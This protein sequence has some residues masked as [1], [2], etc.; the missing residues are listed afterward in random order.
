MLYYWIFSL[1]LALVYAFWMTRYRRDWQATPSAQAPRQAPQT[2]VAVLLAARNEAENVADCLRCLVAQDYPKALLEIW[3]VDDYS[4]DATPQILA[5]WA[6]NYSQVH[7]FSLAHLRK[8]AGKKSA[9]EQAILHSRS[10][11]IVT[12]DADCQMG[13]Q[14]LSQLVGVYEEK[15]ARF[16]AAPVCFHQCQ[17]AFERWQALDFAGMMGITAA[18]IRGRYMYMCNGANLAY[19]RHLFEAVGGF[20]GNKHL[21]SGDDM[22]LL[23]KIAQQ[24]QAG[25]HFVKSRAAVVYTKAKPTWNGFVEQRVRWASKSSAYEQQ[26]VNLQLALVWLF[27]LS[28]LLDGLLFYWGGWPLLG[29]WLGKW[30]LKA[31]VDWRLLRSCCRFFGQMSLLRDFWPALFW[32]FWYILYIG[33]LANVRKSYTWKERQQR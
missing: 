22:L 23:Q 5:E 18:G 25:I 9:M 32:H 29:L 19:P 16:L 11:L 1:A 12:T 2:R 13:P 4:E 14:W 28:L 6:A 20:E 8:P 15:Q 33:L 21:A 10:E 27:M 3:I 31:L 17:T 26:G 30:L 7:S 24:S